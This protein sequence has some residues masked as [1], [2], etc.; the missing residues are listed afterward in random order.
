M[1]LAGIVLYNPDIERLK[2]NVKSILPQVNKLILIDNGSE[3]ISELEKIFSDEKIVLKKN[4]ENKGIATAL[5]YILDYAY[6]N[7]YDWFLT[8]DQDSVADANLINVYKDK[9]NVDN[10]AMI[11]CNIV[12]R[13]VGQLESYNAKSDFVFVKKCITSGTFNNTNILK[14][15]GGFDDKM[16][17]DYVDFDVCASIIENG[18][19]IIKV[20]Y[21]GLLHEVGHTTLKRILWKKEEI[22]NHSSFRTYYIIRNWIYVIK[23]HPSLN[24]LKEKLKLMKR[25]FLIICFQ[26]NKAKNFAAILRGIKDSKKIIKEN[27]IN[28]VLPSLG[29]SGGLKV[30]YKYSELM[31]LRGYD[32]FLYFPI[33]P[34]KLNDNQN[35]FYLF[36]KFIGRFIKYKLFNRHKKIKCNYKIKPVLK[37]NNI[38]IR[39]GYCTIATAWPTAFDV[40]KLA[41]RKGKK[42]YFIQDYEIWDNEV[43][44]KLTYELPLKK[45]A[46]SK[47]IVQQL[48]NQGVKEKIYI[49]NNGLSVNDYSCQKKYDRKMINCLMLAHSLPKKGVEYGLCAF[50]EAKKVNKNLTLKMFGLK[51]YQ[52]IP[53]DI[54]LVVNP[55]KEELRKLYAETDIFIYPSITEGWGLTVVEAMAAKCAIV[56]TSTGCLLDLGVDGYNCL[57]SKPFDTEKMQKNILKISNNRTL[58]KKMGENAFKTV[59]KLSWNDSCENLI[60]I[61]K[62]I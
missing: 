2:E 15:I 16:F 61:I 22:Y 1:F 45:I 39:D 18:F 47:W 41:E 26:E 31:R 38:F 19:K 4:N 23:K 12:D 44:G 3:N 52:N 13:N 32:V 10:V 27:R 14:K 46:I 29:E 56:G 8:L 33:I 20:N 60:K 24:N 42:I 48:E 34:Y 11:T 55:T 50:K 17:I 5:N 40:E 25:C 43:K 21:N 57:L 37:I 9:V 35:N 58:Q 28:F 6:I 62:K 30:I 54:E 59:Q 51:N 36:Y 7:R 49:A 53:K